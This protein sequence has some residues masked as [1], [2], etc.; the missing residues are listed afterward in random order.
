[1]IPLDLI[2]HISGFIETTKLKYCCNELY[3][4]ISSY[5]KSKEWRDKYNYH[6]VHCNISLPAM[7]GDYVWKHEY[8]RIFKYKYWKSFTRINVNTDTFEM[9]H[10]LNKIP[11]ELG[12]LIGL[13]ELRFHGNQLNKVP[14]ELGQLINLQ[15]LSICKGYFFVIIK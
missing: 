5:D 3:T 10:V 4:N 8:L 14:K 9:H 12:Q 15:T 6:L 11:K 2:T 13:T 1:M 7:R